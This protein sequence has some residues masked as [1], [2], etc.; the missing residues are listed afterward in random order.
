VAAAADTDDS[1]GGGGTAW[2]AAYGTPHTIASCTSTAT[3]LA[4]ANTTADSSNNEPL[5]T[6][7]AYIQFKYMAAGAA[8]FGLL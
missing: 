2:N 5:Y 3:T 4:S 1:D 8:I 7:V 6:E